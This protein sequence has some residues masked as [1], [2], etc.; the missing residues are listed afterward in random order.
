MQVEAALGVEGDDILYV[1]DH[2]Y[3][4]AALAKIN[5]RWAASNYWRLQWLLVSQQQQQQQHP[6][7]AVQCFISSHMHL[8]GGAVPARWC[9]VSDVTLP[10]LLLCI[11]CV[12]VF[13]AGGALL[14]SSGSWKRK[15]WHWQLD[16]HTGRVVAV[17]NVHA[18]LCVFNRRGGGAGGAGRSS[19]VVVVVVGGRSGGL[20][21]TQVGVSLR[22]CLCTERIGS[23]CSSGDEAA[24]TP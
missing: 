17:F 20:T 9:I 16:G 4:D 19:T 3:T 12:L 24:G 15:W 13:P 18:R 5:F 8:Y 10:A 14:S 11:W 23:N 7:P 22:L 6:L 1:G 21:T 2:I